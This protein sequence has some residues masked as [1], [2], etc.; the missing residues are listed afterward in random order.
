MLLYIFWYE[1]YETDATVTISSQTGLGFEIR[2]STIY[3]EY[4]PINR[5]VTEITFVGRDNNV[6]GKCS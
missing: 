2:C 6:S 4:Q 3:C 1:T 5:M